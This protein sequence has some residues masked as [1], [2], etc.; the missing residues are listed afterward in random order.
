MTHDKA[1]AGLAAAKQ[2][3]AVD[4]A[5]DEVVVPGGVPCLAQEAILGVARDFSRAA[6]GV[7]KALRDKETPGGMAVLVDRTEE[8]QRVVRAAVGILDDLAADVTLDAHK[9]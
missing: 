5:D 3:G 2:G 1:I 6:Q 9:A 8:A 4:D 7:V